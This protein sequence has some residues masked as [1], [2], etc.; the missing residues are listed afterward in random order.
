MRGQ[1]DCVI[2]N[3]KDW[4]ILSEAWGWCLHYWCTCCFVRGHVHCL[5]GPALCHLLHSH[6]DLRHLLFSPSD[7]L[8]TSALPLVAFPHVLLWSNK[9]TW[10]L[11]SLNHSLVLSLFLILSF[12]YLFPLCLSSSVY[13]LMTISSLPISLCV[14]TVS[15]FS[16]VFCIV[17]LKKLEISQLLKFFG[18]WFV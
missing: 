8:N 11:L 18:F 15:S 6:A 16:L 7:H 1:L 4:R 9:K 17:S 3:T 12:P 13:F 2:V 10:T 5:S 14:R